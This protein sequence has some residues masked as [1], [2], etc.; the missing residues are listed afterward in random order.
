MWIQRDQNGEIIG[1][2]SNPVM[3]NCIPALG[4]WRNGNLDNPEMLRYPQ[5]W[6]PDSEY[7]A[8]KAARPI[9]KPRDLIAEIDAL[10]AKV[11]ILEAK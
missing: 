4:D 1:G 2:S 6:I 11:A 5:E 7:A 8:W 9:N 10:K 3:K